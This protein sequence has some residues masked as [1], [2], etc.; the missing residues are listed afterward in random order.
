VF[1]VSQELE[2]NRMVLPT[3]CIVCD[4]EGAEPVSYVQGHFPVPIP[5]FGGVYTSTHVILPYCEFHAASFRLRFRILRFVQYAIIAVAFICVNV[6][7]ALEREEPEAEQGFN[8]LSGFG[9]FC[10]AI[11]LPGSLIV[12]RLMYDAFFRVKQGHVLVT[13]KHQH[14]L[15]RLN[16]LNVCPSDDEQ[17]VQN[18]NA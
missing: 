15:D 18:K 3:R 10:I 11:L 7:F 1:H 5:A 16:A 17:G 12:R 2:A 4:R 13:S 14:F 6:G 8:A 9:V